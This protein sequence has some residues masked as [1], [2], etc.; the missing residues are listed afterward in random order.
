MRVEDAVVAE[1]DI[2]SDSEDEVPISM[3]LSKR[4]A[5]TSPQPAQKKRKLIKTYQ[6]RL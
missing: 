2:D 5:V 1:M 3:V 6:K 4:K